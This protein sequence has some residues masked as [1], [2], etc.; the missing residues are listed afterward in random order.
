[1]SSKGAGIA[2]AL[3]PSARGL[4]AVLWALSKQPLREPTPQ[5]PRI[6]P[7]RVSLCPP[8]PGAA[9]PLHRA[10]WLLFS[11]WVSQVGLA[12]GQGPVA[13]PLP[14]ARVAELTDKP[15]DT[16]LFLPPL[17]RAQNQVQTLHR[18]LGGWGLPRGES[19]HGGD[20]SSWVAGTATQPA[21]AAAY[22]IATRIP[23][24]CEG[25]TGRDRGR[26][27]LVS[28][29]RAPRPGHRSKLEVQ[30]RPPVPAGALSRQPG[31]PGGL[32]Q[33]RL[34]PFPEPPSKA[35]QARGVEGA[36]GTQV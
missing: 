32:R 24:S 33:G 7:G 34:S 26:T 23:R 29:N 35:P 30:N 27:L 25:G 4:P 18:A 17:S 2:S 8:R 3:D 20:R 1:M 11:S 13:H 14:N 31:R 10:C 12:H 36:A 28:D 22:F 5:Y 16:G 6:P 15:V 21:A 19:A 9:E